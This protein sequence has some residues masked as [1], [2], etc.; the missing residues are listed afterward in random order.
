MTPI[1]KNPNTN[2]RHQDAI[3][4]TAASPLMVRI[5]EPHTRLQQ[6]LH[7]APTTTNLIF[8]IFRMVLYQT[9]AQCMA[10]L[11]LSG[12]LLPTEGFFKRLILVMTGSVFLASLALCIHIG[13]LHIANAVL[14]ECR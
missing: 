9:A 1:E 4:A 14:I 13:F 11:L 10:T 3:T 2:D 12:L 6:T 5:Y 7:Q 8:G